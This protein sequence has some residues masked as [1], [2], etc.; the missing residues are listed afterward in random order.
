MTLGCRGSPS[1]PSAWNDDLGWPGR[2]VMVTWVSQASLT[3]I[4]PHLR[5]PLRSTSMPMHFHFKICFSKQLF[6][7]MSAMQL[8][9]NQEALKGRKIRC[10][11]SRVIKRDRKLVK[12]RLQKLPASS[13]TDT[14]SATSGFGGT[15]RRAGHFSSG[16]GGTGAKWLIC[17]QS[18]MYNVC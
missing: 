17:Q 1:I 2:V 9:P 13:V 3:Q 7:G 8:V 6:C 18:C 4:A 10:S 12:K 16:F 11:V 5:G 15:G 14:H